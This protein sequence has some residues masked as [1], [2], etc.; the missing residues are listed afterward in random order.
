MYQFRATVQ[1]GKP[2]FA[3]DG[4]TLERAYLALE[5]R[6]IVLTIKRR[7]Q[8]RSLKANALYWVYL[9]NISSETGH[10]PN[11]LHEFFKAK[12]LSPRFET[13]YNEEVE[14]PPSTAI[15]SSQ[16]FSAY[17]ERICAM[18]GVPIPEVML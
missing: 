11:E 1:G 8:V 10:T 6:E 16:E 14:L 2:R 12:F 4:A 17:M 13:I 3:D 5:G 18:T 15:L 9:T 7:S